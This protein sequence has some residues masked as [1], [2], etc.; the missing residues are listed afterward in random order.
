MHAGIYSKEPAVR[1][2]LEFPPHVAGQDIQFLPIL[3][4]RPASDG[5]ALFFEKLDEFEVAVGFAHGF[6]FYKSKER[7]LDAGVA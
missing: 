6:L 7:I 3:G 4:Y 1:K 2:R 5:D